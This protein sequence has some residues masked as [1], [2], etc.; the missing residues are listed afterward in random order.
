MKTSNRI[1][2]STVA[3]AMVAA[4]MLA[5]G[6]VSVAT[7]PLPKRAKRAVPE[8]EKAIDEF[9]A[10]DAPLKAGLVVDSASE[11]SIALKPETAGQAAGIEATDLKLASAE[12]ATSPVDPP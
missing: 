4:F 2:N 7:T 8:A 5:S 1:L 3:A 11:S 9:S 10:D 12:I 6:E